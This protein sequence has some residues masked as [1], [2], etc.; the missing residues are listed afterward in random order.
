MVDNLSARNQPNILKDVDKQTV[1]IYQPH[2]ATSSSL[3]P[4]IFFVH[5][6]AW[7]LGN[8]SNAVEPCETLAKSGYVCVATSYSLS[9]ISDEQ[10]QVALMGIT[11]IMLSVALTCATFCQMM[12]FMALWLVI[13]IFLVLLWVFVPQEGATHPDHIQDVAKNFAWTVQNIKEYG[14]DPANVYLMGHSAGGHLVSLLATNSFYITELGLSPKTIKGCISVSGIYSD[15][16]LAETQVGRQ[17]MRNAFGKRKQYYDAF[18][19]YN[20][21][22]DT[23]PPVLLLNAGVDIS[24]KRHTLDFHYALRQSGVFV[25]TVYFEHNTHWNIMKNWDTKNAAVMTAVQDF[26]REAETL[27]KH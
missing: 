18:P 26:I 15:K 10:I 2:D 21:S 23:T 19:I 9:N 25:Q 16:R 5:G 14:G 7:Q 13:I 20:I 24:T 22:S 8:K 27:S 4:V 11:I 1:D 3:K 6:G 12:L 17:I